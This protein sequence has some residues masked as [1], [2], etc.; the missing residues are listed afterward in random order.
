MQ[1][2]D[3]YYSCLKCNAWVLGQHFAYHI[4]ESQIA[5]DEHGCEVM[6][7]GILQSNLDYY[8]HR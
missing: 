7:L 6:A 2:K 1:H 4:Y 8:K 5:K 3:Y